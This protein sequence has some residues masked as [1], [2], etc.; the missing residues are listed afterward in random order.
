MQARSLEEPAPV[1]RSHFELHL[2]TIAI[3]R[4]RHFD[5]G[6][7]ER[8]DSAKQ[9]CELADFRAADGQHD[10]AGAQIGLARRTAAREADDDHPV[11]DLRGVAPEPWARRAVAR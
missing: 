8:P 10:V 3:N 4:H 7:A 5:A 2:T 11:V 6:I 1:G 9:A